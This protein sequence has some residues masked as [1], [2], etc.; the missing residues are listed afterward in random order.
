MALCSEGWVCSS[1]L[2][3]TTDSATTASSFFE[4]R[5]TKPLRQV[6]ETP[7]ILEAHLP[8]AWMVAATNS[9]S[10]WEMYVWNSLKIA[11][12]LASV[13]KFVK[14]SSLRRRICSG[15]ELDRTKKDLRYGS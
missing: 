3:T 4:S 11:E 7:L 1:F 14:I 5:A 13:A 9:L 8:I 10:V 2:T 12:M 15:S 6:S